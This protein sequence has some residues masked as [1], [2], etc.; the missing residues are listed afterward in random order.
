MSLRRPATRMSLLRTRREAGHAREGLRLLRSKREALM[1]AFLASVRERVR[2]HD[3]LED[4]CRQ[5]AEALAEA[6]GAEGRPGVESYGWAARRE[7]ALEVHS[8]V[9]WGIP[10]ATFRS[11]PFV[12]DFRQR[13]FDPAAA[14]YR[15]HRAADRFEELLALI[16]EAA[17]TDVR[18]KRLGAEI[19]KTS[20]RINALEERL[21]PTLDAAEKRIREHLDERERDEGQRLRRLK[22]LRAREA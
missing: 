19:Q 7:F 15:I 2:Y 12:R 22:K 8:E 1:K 6:L 17:A 4:K 16:L 18:L 21:I 13:G 10:V 20:R 9:I 11:L 14:G 3:L 5:A